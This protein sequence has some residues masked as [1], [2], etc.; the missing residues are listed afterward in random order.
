MEFAKGSFQNSI[1]LPLLTDKEREII[2]TTYKQKGNKEAVALGHKIV[3]GDIKEK[4]INLWID[5]IKANPNAYLFCWRGGQRSAI[6]QEWL[7]DRGVIIPRLKGGYKAFR[8]Y[9]IK[10]SISISSS[11][12]IYNIAGRTG[13]G[14]TLLL[15]E[16]PQ[17]IDLEGIAHHRGS[18]FGRYALA[19][20]SQISFEN[21]LAY[22]LILHNEHKYPWL[23][24]EDESRNVGQRYIPPEVFNSFKNAK[25]VLLE[26]P[27][28]E[29]I[30]I[31]YDDYIIYSQ[32]EYEEAY[33]KGQTP[34]TWYEVMQYNFQRIR[35][36][37]GEERYKRL[38][39]LLEIAWNEQICRGNRE[40][41]K[42]W[43]ETLLVE[44][45]DPMY[46][47]QIKKK[48]EQIIFKGNQEEILE[49]FSSLETKR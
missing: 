6:V 11:S 18:A 9:L 19:Q 37:L 38:I 23:I 31:I 43:I 39:K 26:R 27:L 32:Q 35:K 24:I 16:F 29:R 10:E 2:G 14:K 25:L 49:F 40:L 8:N 28:Q 30:D 12:K 5:F 47:Y 45:Y 42:D 7:A 46:D 17:A 21:N 3:S 44:Y 36:R 15:K 4:R 13:S 1:N 20:P 33:N 34:Y 22:E 48:I 41:H